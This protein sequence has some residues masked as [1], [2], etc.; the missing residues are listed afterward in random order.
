MPVYEYICEKCGSTTEAIRRMSDADAVIACEKCG[1]K[2]TK[3]AH[4]L[5]AVGGTSSGSG[6][7]P[8]HHH[9]GGGCG[10]CGGGGGG[11]GCPME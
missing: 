4:S 6:T 5:C 9:H 11:G 7:A 2:K 3:R 10:C 1:S 8:A